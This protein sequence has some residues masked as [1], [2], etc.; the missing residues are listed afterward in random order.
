[1]YI[2]PSATSSPCGVTLSNQL[3]IRNFISSAARSVKVK[4]TILSLGTPWTPTHHAIRLAI[5]SVLPEPAPAT[6][7]SRLFGHLTDSFCFAVKFSSSRLSILGMLFGPLVS[8][9]RGLYESSHAF[10]VSSDKLRWESISN[11]LSRLALPTP[12][13]E[14]IVPGKG[15]E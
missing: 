15:L 4:A 13:R 11:E 10:R 2:P 5:T 8:V 12:E 1:M 7:K 14:E 9:C 3:R 6:T